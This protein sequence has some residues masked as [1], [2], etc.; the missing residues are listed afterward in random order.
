[1]KPMYIEPGEWNLVEKIL[2]ARGPPSEHFTVVVEGKKGRGKSSYAIQ[3]GVRVLKYAY[4]LTDQEAWEAIKGFI[5]WTPVQY[6]NKIE[7][8]EK[9]IGVA[10][11]IIWDDAG[12]WLSA[13]KF[14]EQ[15]IQ[16]VAEY[17]DLA[18]THLVCTILTSPRST[19]ITRRVRVDPGGL[20]VRIVK[21]SAGDPWKRWAHIYRW[22]ESPD[23]KRVGTSHRLTDEFNCK[24]PDEFFAWYDP[25]RRRYEQAARKVFAKIWGQILEKEGIEGEIWHQPIVVPRRDQA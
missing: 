1:M 9:T 23:E 16:A 20:K 11:V 21:V 3:V 25:L 14:R 4:G 17:N 6:A 10:P 5:V 7:E 15:A 12:Y 18:R 19:S 8:I 24:L 22:W 13:Y 2:K